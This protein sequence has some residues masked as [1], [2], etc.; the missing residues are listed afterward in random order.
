MAKDGVWS[1]IRRGDPFYAQGER[2]GQYRRTTN[3][4]S[5]FDHE[6]GIRSPGYCLM[7]DNGFL[8]IKNPCGIP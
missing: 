5:N 4:M 1:T 8:F 6:T 3:S 7:G 2:D